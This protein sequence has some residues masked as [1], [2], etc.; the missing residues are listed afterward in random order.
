MNTRSYP[1]K[2]SFMPVQYAFSQLE[3]DQFYDAASRFTINPYTDIAGFI[4]AVDGLD[5]E[6]KN[7]ADN[8]RSAYQSINFAENPAFYLKG[9]PM[10]KEL[11]I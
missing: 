4:H 9:C 5:S 1:H 10:D 11:P 6:L 3:R 8:I 2:K 7:I